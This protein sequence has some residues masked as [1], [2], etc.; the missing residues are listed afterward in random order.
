M[1]KAPKKADAR[2]AEAREVKEMPAYKF[3]APPFGSFTQKY[4]APSER[5]ERRE[6]AGKPLVHV[7]HNKLMSNA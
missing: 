1:S 5:K 3:Q 6:E 7:A 2:P 4:R